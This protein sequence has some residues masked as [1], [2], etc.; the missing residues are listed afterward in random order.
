MLCVLN[1]LVF[2]HKLNDATDEIRH[3]AFAEVLR[4]AQKPNAA[5]GQLSNV[6]FTLHSVAEE[7]RKGM[8]QDDVDF[9]PLVENRLHHPRELR[10]MRCSPRKS[11]ICELSDN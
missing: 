7:T 4:Y 9:R 8:D 2:V 11:G 10:A 6:E 3:R 1:A 5:L